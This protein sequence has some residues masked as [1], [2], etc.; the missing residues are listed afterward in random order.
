MKHQN[1]NI[2]ENDR[3]EDPVNVTKDDIEKAQQHELKFMLL[4]LSFGSQQPSWGHTFG[5]EG[6][7]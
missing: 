5:P 7:Q 2:A 4:M 6:N 3:S 1:N